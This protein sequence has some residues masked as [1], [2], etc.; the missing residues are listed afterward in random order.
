MKL[1]VVVECGCRHIIHLKFVAMVYLGLV[2]ICHGLRT[3]SIYISIFVSSFQL[4]GRGTPRLSR[5]VLL[6]AGQIRRPGGVWIVYLFT[7]LSDVTPA[8]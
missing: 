2:A 1:V 8:S 3:T 6:S 4:C 7:S 5:R